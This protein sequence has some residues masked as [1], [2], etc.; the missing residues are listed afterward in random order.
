MRELR[1][2][3]NAPRGYCDFELIGT[4][5]ALFPDDDK[6]DK[7]G[8]VGSRA[9]GCLSLFGLEFELLKR[10]LTSLGSETVIAL[11]RRVLDA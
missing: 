1:V 11:S 9:A 5:E 3:A 10:P 2:N 8:E 6:D 4:F 7:V